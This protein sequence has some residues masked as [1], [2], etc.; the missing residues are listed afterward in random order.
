MRI[1]PAEGEGEVVNL[2]WERTITITA[3]G[4]RDKTG[5]L[6]KNALIKCDIMIFEWQILKNAFF[7]LKLSMCDKFRKPLLVM[8]CRDAYDATNANVKQNHCYFVA[9]R[10]F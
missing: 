6:Q 7:K 2:S 4:R 5:K 3:L 9:A 10:K 8:L 1:A